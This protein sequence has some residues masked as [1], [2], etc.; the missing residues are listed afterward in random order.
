MSDSLHESLRQAMTEVEFSKFL[1]FVEAI[2]SAEK[3]GRAHF[4]PVQE[5]ERFSWSVKIL[6]AVAA[7]FDLAP[8]VPHS[9]DALAY[10]VREALPGGSVAL[11]KATMC[12][13]AQQS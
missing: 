13:L 5:S 10:L 6:A 9:S 2:A 7:I 1:M 11:V 8:D 4:E 12:A 3:L